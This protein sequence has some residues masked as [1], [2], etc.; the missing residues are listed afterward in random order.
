MGAW[1]S[2][3]FDNDDAAD[4]LYELECCDDLSVIEQALQFEEDYIEAPEGCG[5]LAAA[6]VVLALLGKARTGFPESAAEWVNNHKTLDANSL[7]DSAIKAVTLVL[8]EQSELVE[9]WEET[10]DFSVWKKDVNEIR[11]ILE[12]S[13]QSH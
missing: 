4:W 10:S 3:T 8:S 12:D 11:S 13:L 1:D 5:A 9:L 6:E 2:N 7:K